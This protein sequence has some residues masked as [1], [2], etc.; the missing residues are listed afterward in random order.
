M[1]HV[2]TIRIYQVVTGGRGILKQNKDF[3]PVS[4]SGRLLGGLGR[5]GPGPCSGSP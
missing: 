3:L 4:F 5:L 1:W 2:T